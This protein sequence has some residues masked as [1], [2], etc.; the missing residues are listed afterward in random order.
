MNRR[1]SQLTKRRAAHAR[2]ALAPATGRGRKAAAAAAEE[3]EEDDEEDEEEADPQDV[4][5]RPHMP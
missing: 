1:F 2:R 4:K 5:V 3:E